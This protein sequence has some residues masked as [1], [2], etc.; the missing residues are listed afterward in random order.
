L[1]KGAV[2]LNLLLTLLSFLLLSFAQAQG[3]L[4]ELGV[5]RFFKEGHVARLKN[6]RV[7]LITN[8]TGVSSDLKR[9]ADLFKEGAGEFKLV[10]YFCPEHGLNGSAY[11]FAHIE[12]SKE[13]SGIPVYSLHGATRRPTDKMLTGIDV[14]I[15][16]IQEIGVRS[17]TY[18]ATLFYAMEEAAKRKIKVV[19]LDRPNPISGVV[20]DGPMLREKWR[21]FV[22]YVN[23]P[24][25]HGMTIGELARFFNEEYKV[26]CDLAVIP[27]RGWQRNMSYK[28]TGL[29]WIPTSPYV[30]EQDTPLFCATTGI[31]GELGCV[32]IGIGYTLPFKLVGAPWVDGKLFAAR[33]NAQKFPGVTFI[34]FYYRPMTGLFSGKDCQGVKI[35]ITDSSR[36]RPLATSYLLIGMLKA[37]YPKQ[38]N[39]ALAKLDNARRKLFCQ[40]NGNEEILSLLIKEKYAAWPMIRVDEEERKAFMQKRQK[41]L[42]Y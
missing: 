39:K 17:Y 28:D 13:A 8:H 18:A 33:L 41:Y 32:N 42:L 10:A 15:F 7:G 30:P 25:C 3:A 5:D 6:K 35:V 11:A 24:Y 22:G 2:A 20:V 27:M 37:L 31:L 29:H 16:D 40:V 21:S 38:I 1:E 36:Y 19:V 34:P 12:D 23:V 9:T 26:G 4:V 14:L